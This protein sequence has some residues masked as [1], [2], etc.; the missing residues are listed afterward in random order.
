MNDSYKNAKELNND[1][2]NIEDSIIALNNFKE[3]LMIRK[4]E[5][6]DKIKEQL[7]DIK[8][9]KNA[10]EGAIFVVGAEL[11]SPV[12]AMGVA[13]IGFGIDAIMVPLWGSGL[14]VVAVGASMGVLGVL[15]GILEKEKK[16]IKQLEGDI[17]T[18]NDVFNNVDESTKKLVKSK[19]LKKEA[20]DNKYLQ[21]V[22]N[23]TRE[24]IFKDK[25]L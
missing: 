18:C 22:V 10:Y 25:L 24:K 4:E 5:I 7:E 13:D 11:L 3:E 14:Y 20:L 6:R 17:E 19:K 21:K 15:G 12:V 23:E 16:I 8:P 9:L 1:I 2:K